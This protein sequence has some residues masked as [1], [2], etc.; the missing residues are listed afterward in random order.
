M[1]VN[2]K[3]RLEQLKLNFDGQR[4]Y[5]ARN[6]AYVFDVFDDTW[7]LDTKDYLY[8]KW[9]L[10]IGYDDQTLTNLRVLLAE[11]AHQLSYNS[12]RI[13]CNSLKF[14]GNNLSPVAFQL[15]WLSILDSYKN[16]LAST[17]SFAVKNRMYQ[18][19]EITNYISENYSPTKWSGNL[20][21]DPQK[22][23][24]SEV[25]YQSIMEQLRLASDAVHTKTMGFN[26]LDQQASFIAAQLIIALVRRPV[27]L[28]ELKWADILPVGQHFSEHRQSPKESVPESEPLF[29][30]VECW[31]IRI[32]KGKDGQFR[33][34]VES[35]SK[36]L[37]PDLSILILRYRQRYEN[38]LIE[39]L[40]KQTIILTDD[41]RHQIMLRCP[42]FADSS[43]FTTSFSNKANLFKALGIMSNSFHK[44]SLYIRTN[45]KRFMEKLNIKSDRNND[46]LTLSNN[47][48]RH[49]ILTSGA[50]MGLTSSYLA[51]IT[52]VVEGSVKP[53][54]DLDFE[55]RVD[56]DQAFI[57]NSILSRFAKT[58]VSDLLKQD[59]FV[60]RNEF[61]EEIGIQ[62]NP[63]NCSSCASK[64]GAPM[65]CYPCDNFVANEDGNH[66]EYLDKALHK[67]KV[68]KIEGNKTTVKKLKII[69]MYIQ[70]TINI[71]NERK[72]TKRGVEND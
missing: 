66:Q 9:M 49:T 6:D 50:K 26:T 44:K 18:F 64:L 30:D 34:S 70:G 17:F 4:R 8:L 37:E 22:G 42:L 23:C 71:C 41:E 43:L 45:I 19:Q 58:S 20:I 46:K 5:R 36:R 62:E 56:I 28:S 69:I 48:I 12:V 51:A 47:R 32:F 68:N 39:S 40:K 72:L 52:G 54:I 61:D 53:Y 33:G 65:G 25:E 2:N 59:G 29:S 10:D 14:L 27:Q 67:Y 55:S 57:Q 16:V 35:T 63:A 38:T 31:H 15:K 24:Y 13:R 11:T 1:G 7:Q 21:L 3:K 60:I